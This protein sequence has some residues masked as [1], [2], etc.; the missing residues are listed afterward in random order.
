LR[1]ESTSCA[2]TNLAG[3]EARVLQ[4]RIDPV[5]GHD[6]RVEERAA[7]RHLF[8]NV[9]PLAV[10]ELD[11]VA[12]HRMPH[13]VGCGR[14]LV[15]DPRVDVRVVPLVRLDRL[16]PEKRRE[17]LVVG[18][19]LQFGDD[20]GPRLL[21]DLL[22]AQQRVGGRDLAGDAVVLPHHERVNGRQLDVFVSADV[23]GD[24]HLVGRNRSLVLVLEAASVEREKVAVAR[25]ES[26]AG[27]FAKEGGAG[28]ID[29]INDRAVEECRDLV[30]LLARVGRT[31][32]GGRIKLGP[33]EI[34]D[35]RAGRVG[36][37]LR[38]AGGDRDVERLLLVAD[39]VV[40]DAE[41]VVDEL[42]PRVDEC[43]S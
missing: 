32:S 36:I 15:G 34:D 19:D 9:V 23:A 8:G 18:N 29:A 5:L 4:D 41:V 43:G 16:G 7:E 13:A 35:L 30:E 42:A 12:E 22:V 3:S 20:L 31:G 37:E 6:A 14:E 40:G 1:T 17:E 2:S 38:V 21:E 11:I 39:T 27:S 10:K 24:E 28:G 25:L 26:P 33:A